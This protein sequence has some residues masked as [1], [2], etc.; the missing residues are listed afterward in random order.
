MTGLRI[1]LF[2]R[3]EVRFD[4]Q[5]VPGL[6]TRKAQEL[7]AFLLLHKD[8][9]HS[10]E[11]LASM[12]W[13]GST[14]RQARKY[15]RHTLWQ[16]QSAL[17]SGDSRNSP[18]VLAGDHDWLSIDP[19]S[20]V[21]IDSAELERAYLLVRG[22]SGR[23]FDSQQSEIVRRAVGLYRGDLLEGWYDDWCLFERERM[24][25]MYLALLGKL[26]LYCEAEGEYELGLECGSLALQCDVAYERIHRRMMR[27][28]YLSGDRTA[29]LRQYQ[30]CVAFLR[31]EL[32]V[33]P[34]ARTVA[35]HE[36]IRL[37]RPLSSVAAMRDH[38]SQDRDA[39][40]RG[41]QDTASQIPAWEL[42]SRQEALEQLEHLQAS[43]LE[44]QSRFEETF[45]AFR[46]TRT[47]EG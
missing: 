10:R 9:P 23:Q 4:G 14:T 31:E 40:D 3:F 29:A 8:R 25:R 37:D 18:T 35:L 45:A 6:E 42:S 43:F 21:W 47:R 12:M 19:D 41:S 24:Q 26:M 36:W 30:R 7:F 22:I 39:Q 46:G 2:S 15:L 1:R 20:D 34:S 17:Q 16:L 11:I 28:H 13:P 38:D 32:E 33:E 5:I 27:L 44:L